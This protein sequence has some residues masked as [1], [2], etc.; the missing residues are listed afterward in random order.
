MLFK[1]QGSRG[2][3][4][5]SNSKTYTNRARC[6][7]RIHPVFYLAFVRLATVGRSRILT[8]IRNPSVY[9]DTRRYRGDNKSS[10]DA[11]PG[12]TRGITRLKVKDPESIPPWRPPTKASSDATKKTSARSSVCASGVGTHLTQRKPERATD[13]CPGLTGRVLLSMP[14]LALAGCQTSVTPR[15]RVSKNTT[16]N[17]Q[18][19][20]AAPCPP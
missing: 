4:Y 11:T 13:S 9:T 12:C 20:V 15:P 3:G 16:H 5:I 6:L 14:S 10:S 18:T 2:R 1:S 8:F 17:R 19:A 7:A